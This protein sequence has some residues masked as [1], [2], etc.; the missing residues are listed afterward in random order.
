MI[1]FTSFVTLL[2][3]AFVFPASAAYLDDAFKES[4]S[5]QQLI[6]CNKRNLGCDGGSTTISAKYLTKNWFGGIT[7]LNDYPYTD[8][9]GLTS[10]N[11]SLR[12]QTPALAV[13]VRD[14]ITIGGL[15]TTMSFD[16]RLEIF[17]LALMEKPISI[18]LKSSCRILSN[19][20][21]G[22]LT[23]DGD[24]ACSNSTCYDH[25]VLMVGYDD[26]DET[27][28]FKLKN[29]WG[30]RWGE[31]GYFRVAQRGKGAFGLFGIFGEG[32]MVEVQQNIDA[33]MIEV[34]EDNLFPIWAIVTISMLSSL[35]CCFCTYTACVCWA[36]KRKE[37]E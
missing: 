32:V 31:G 9:S 10:N 3:F 15:H 22:I 13:E 16:K 7:T 18:I 2:F 17:K 8:A 11:C 24:C 6:S 25:A 4:M 1:L 37:Y 23:E 19:Y 14:P 26:T 36:R 27:P 29:S 21:S 12:Q 20:V 34:M 30:T 5:F 28:Y 33:G 35:C